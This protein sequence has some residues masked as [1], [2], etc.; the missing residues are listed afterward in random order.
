M[1]NKS[2]QMIQHATMKQTIGVESS[3][4]V[5]TVNTI[6]YTQYTLHYTYWDWV[7]KWKLKLMNV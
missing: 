1:N 4:K 7:Q 2:I 3:W 5:G 6:Q